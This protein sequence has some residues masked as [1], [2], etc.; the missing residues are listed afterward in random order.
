MDNNLEDMANIVI[1]NMKTIPG[2]SWA[3]N[4]KIDLKDIQRHFGEW[5]RIFRVGSDALRTLLTSR[6]TKETSSV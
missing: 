4:I 2:S 1:W 5:V 3:S 6:I